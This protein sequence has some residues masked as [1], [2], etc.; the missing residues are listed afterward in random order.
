[1]A[2]GPV[3]LVSPGVVRYVRNT[4]VPPRLASVATLLGSGPPS[5]MQPV[6]QIILLLRGMSDPLLRTRDPCS[7]SK[8]WLHI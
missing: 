5:M 4:W 7:G 2:P 3:A 6:L 8:P 1:M